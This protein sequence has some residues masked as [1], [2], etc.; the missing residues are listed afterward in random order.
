MASQ[1]ERSSTR[2]TLRE[3]RKFIALGETYIP[4]NSI[5]SKVDDSKR[6]F[7]LID[8]STLDREDALTLQM[9]TESDLKQRN[10]SSGS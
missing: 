4:N 1:Y 3:R 5:F 7:N 2:R 8:G 10:S 9:K 6:I